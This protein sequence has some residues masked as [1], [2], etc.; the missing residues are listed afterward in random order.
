[1]TVRTRPILRV[2]L[3][4]A[5]VVAFGYASWRASVAFE[6]RPAP[7]LHYTRL[8]GRSVPLDSLR[9]KVVL[10]NFWA[11]SCGP[12][13]RKMPRMVAAQQ[14]FG[15]RGYETVAIA[16]PYDMPSRVVQFAE[17]RRLPFQ[18][19]LDPRG[20]A[21]RAFG[22]VDATPTSFLINRRGEIVARYRGEPGEGQLE[23]EIER[24]LAES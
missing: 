13:V 16:M 15:E 5:L 18:V 20:D 8:D 17:S 12:C 1:M 7:E 14:R 22:G 19:V 24:W 10:V 2:A 6:P 23:A 4:A 9:G 21:V 3:A 11:T